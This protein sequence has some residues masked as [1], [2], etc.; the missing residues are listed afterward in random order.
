[1]NFSSDNSYGVADEIMAAVVAANR[2]AA[3]SYGGD[4]WSTR[5]S[6]RFAE[7]FEHEVE[8]FLVPTGTAANALSVATLTPAH[9]AVFCHAESHIHLEEC[10]ACEFYALG[11]RL[12]PV[13]GFAGRMTV[14]GLKAALAR[15]PGIRHDLVPSALSLTQSTEC[16]TVYPVDEIAALAGLAHENGL[17]VHMDGAR[18]ANAAAALGH[19]PADI[20]WRAGIDILSF[21]ATKNGAIAAEAVIVFDRARGRDLFHRRKRG[22]LL[23]SKTRFLAAQLEAYLADD[24]WLRLA[25]HANAMAARLATGLASLPAVRLAWPV[26]ANEVFPVLPCALAAKLRKSGAVFHDWTASG[27]AGTEHAPSP[28]E[29]LVRMVTSFRTEAGDIDALIAAARRLAGGN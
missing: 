27:L 8:V 17:G 12:V 2:G 4:D 14:P 11:A 6:A 3:V 13:G 7:L 29:C 22:G 28:D 5:V 24:L 19:A 20:T 15:Y 25:S 18:F 21:G 16:G 26:E 9:G 10:G 1:L 23:V